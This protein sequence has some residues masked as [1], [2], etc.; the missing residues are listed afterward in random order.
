MKISEFVSESSTTSG[1]IA[2]SVASNMPTMKRGG[3]LLTGKKTNKKYANSVV[4]E[5]TDENLKEHDL[6]INPHSVSKK[7]RDLISKTDVRT[8]QEIKM[9]RSDLIQCFKNSKKVYE[10]IKDKSEDE[11]I[12]AW[13]QE[14]IIKS[15][16]YLNTIREYLEGE[17]YQNSEER[18]CGCDSPCDC[19]TQL[20]ELN[21]K[22]AAGAAALGA[23]GLMANLS[24]PSK[25]EPVLN[26]IQSQ[27]QMAQRSGDSNKVM[28]L[29]RDFKRT[30]D[31]ID[32]GRGV[33]S[34]VMQKYK[35]INEEAPDIESAAREAQ[36]I[37]SDYRH[38]DAHM[39]I[40]TAITLLAQDIGIDKNT[41]D[42]Y[43]GDVMEKHGDLE[44]S[45]YALEDMFKDALYSHK[46]KNELDEGK[47]SG[48][49]KK[50][51]IGMWAAKKS[52][53]YGEKPA[54]DLPKS[55]VTK[56]H[57]IAKKVK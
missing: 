1:S 5:S 28:Q 14:K 19:D 16:D 55:V 45:I 38:E 34:D 47:R 36:R 50:Y 10:L 31:S 15:T 33:P 9:A 29:K 44:S 49:D 22:H 51:A 40:I 13:V 56:A 17:Q 32:L 24:D 54:H 39:Q 48:K 27:M 11:G 23:A 12:P 20:S 43:V 18:G 2:P 26:A 7:H 53:G 30:K 52:A 35:P 25:N 37:V 8:D 3:N 41:I 21:W 6:I 4:A 57:K 42:Q 46:L